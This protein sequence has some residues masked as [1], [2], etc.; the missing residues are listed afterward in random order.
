MPPAKKDVLQVRLGP[1]ASLDVVRQRDDKIFLVVFAER[2]QVQRRTI[3]KIHFDQAVALGKF[4]LE[5]P[6]DWI[7]EIREFVNEV[8]SVPEPIAEEDTDVRTPPGH[9]P[10]SGE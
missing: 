7:E 6:G 3:V 4:L 1:L 10:D 2:G 5:Q 9:K 8:E